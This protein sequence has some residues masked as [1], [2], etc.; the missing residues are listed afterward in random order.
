MERSERQTE[1]IFALA[2][3]R[4]VLDFCASTFQNGVELNC[5]AAH[6]EMEAAQRGSRMGR[7]YKKFKWRNE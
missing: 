6:K 3:E 7:A 4:A 5:E 1:F 2:A